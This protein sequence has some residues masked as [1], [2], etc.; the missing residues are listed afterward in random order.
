[1]TDKNGNPVLKTCTPASIVNAVMEMA[2]QGLNPAKQ[3]CYFIAYGGKLTMQRS[4]LGTI[5]M[6]KRLK[7]VADV[8]G[9]TVYDTDVFKVGFNLATGKLE[10]KEYEPSLERDPNKIKGAFAL[11]IGTNGIVHTEWMTLEEIKAAWN[12]GQTKGSSPAHKNFSSEM[13]KKTVINRACKLYAKTSND[14]GLIANLI[15]NDNTREDLEAEINH[16][17]E[18]SEEAEYIDVDGSEVLDVKNK[19]VEPNEVTQDYRP[20]DDEVMF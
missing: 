13:C 14:D 18:M 3:Q 17:E 15:A 4:Y 6:T 12:M 2:T 8:V 20:K 7:G 9:Y 19:D 5:A 10:V 11:I 16:Q 1:T